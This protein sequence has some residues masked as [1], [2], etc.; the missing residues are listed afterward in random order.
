[1]AWKP[2]GSEEDFFKFID[3]Y[4][5]FIRRHIPGDYGLEYG[6]RPYMAGIYRHLE[7]VVAAL[8]AGSRILDLGAGRGHF[9]AYLRARGLDAYGIDVRSVER[10]GDDQ[11]A[12]Q[13]IDTARWYPVLWRAARKAYGVTLKYFDGRR[14]P[15]PADTF[16][17]VLF[18]ASYEHVPVRDIQMIT[19]ESFRTLKPG[20]RTFI[21][22]CPSSWSP[23]E[24]LGK[25]AGMDVH[26]KLYGAGELKR[27][28]RRAGYRILKFSR[29]DFFPHY[30]SPVQKVINAVEPYY[31][32]VEKV[33]LW[34]P[35][36]LFFHHFE[37]VASK[38]AAPARR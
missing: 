17:S 20:G 34:T 24:R 4:G 18:Y 21:F 8:P 33:L 27:N 11:F 2:S 16:D 37:V 29:T 28:L 10:F 3:L 38:P 25:L 12:D 13:D 5:K 22:R 32:S 35:L 6:S 15:F 14:I 26:P 23:T 7:I 1:M 30:F 19:E 9:T 36:R 31:D